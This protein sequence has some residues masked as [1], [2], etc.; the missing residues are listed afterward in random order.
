VQPK[1][2]KD[3]RDRT[4]GAGWRTMPFRG[5]V[6]PVAKASLSA[7]LVLACSKSPQV[8]AGNADSLKR[9]LE[10]APVAAD[11]PLNDAAKPAPAAPS[12]PEAPAPQAKEKAQPAAR[13]SPRPTPSAAPAA[14]KEAASP[15]APVSAPAP[16]RVAEL[17][18]PIGTGIQAALQDSISSRR[19]KVGDIVEARVAHDVTDPAGRVVIPSGARVPLTIAELAPAKGKGAADG[20]LAFQASSVTVSGQTYSLT[21]QV[22]PVHHELRGRGISAGEAEKVGVGTAIGAI[23]G[24]IIGG[25]ATGAVVGGVVGAAGGT[26]VAVETASRDV[27]VGA[28]T[29]V[30]L[31]LTAP[32]VV[33]T[34]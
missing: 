29:T 20:K 32:L 27:V 15:V 12:A 31:T 17:T 18:L 5:R 34:R 24:R 28:G 11:Q 14:G 2:D 16:L 6:L 21:A 26:A 3:H 8:G 9:D 22:Q 7:L 4:S 13:R 23:A 10:L 25:N 30:D 19:N 33:K 1:L